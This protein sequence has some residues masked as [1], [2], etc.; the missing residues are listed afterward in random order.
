MHKLFFCAH[1]A[2]CLKADGKEI[3]VL[4]LVSLATDG[5]GETDPQK[6]CNQKKS[7]IKIGIYLRNLKPIWSVGCGSKRACVWGGR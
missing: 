5:A 4:N 1:R 6:I 7:H 2:T 3:R